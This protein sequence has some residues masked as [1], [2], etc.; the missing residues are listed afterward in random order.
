MIRI[1][2][3]ICR[4]IYFK[5]MCCGIKLGQIFFLILLVALVEIYNFVGFANKQMLVYLTLVEI[6]VKVIAMALPEF[7]LLFIYS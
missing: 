1:S 3:E 7:V 4:S 5:I 2:F 6:Y